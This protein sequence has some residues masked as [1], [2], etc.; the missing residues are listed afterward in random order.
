MRTGSNRLIAAT[1]FAK[2]AGT[3]LNFWMVHREGRELWYYIGTRDQYAGLDRSK[4]FT[5]GTRTLQF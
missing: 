3:G 5:V 2:A 1:N 4:S